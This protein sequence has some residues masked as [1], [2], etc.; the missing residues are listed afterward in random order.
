[1]NTEI[2]L[3]KDCEHCRYRHQNLCMCGVAVKV[4]IEPPKKRRRCAKLAVLGRER[5]E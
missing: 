4:L 2:Y 3:T 1:M 5:K